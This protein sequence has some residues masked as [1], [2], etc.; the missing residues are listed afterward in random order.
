MKIAILPITKER[1]VAIIADKDDNYILED[2]SIRF[3]N[4]GYNFDARVIHERFVNATDHT[5]TVLNIKG[6]EDFHFPSSWLNPINGMIQ[7]LVD[8]GI[9]NQK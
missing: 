8:A 7:N 3:R 4:I 2:S 9:L 5:I 6:D 1:S